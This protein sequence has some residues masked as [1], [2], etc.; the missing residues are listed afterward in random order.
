MKKMV[1]ICLN[2][3]DK[4]G[5][6]RS[7]GGIQTYLYQLAKLGQTLNLMPVI[8]QCADIPFSK[9]IDGIEVVGVKVSYSKFLF[10]VKRQLYKSALSII[11]NNN[12]V[13][14]FGTE[15]LCV[16]SDSKK[17]ICIQ[18]GIDWDLPAHYLSR[19]S[20]KWMIYAWLSKKIKAHASKSNIKKVNTVVC[21]DYN[22]LNWYRACVVDF[23]ISKF[24]VIPNF[25]DVS[26]K[27][28]SSKNTSIKNN[29]DNI[30][31]LFARRFYEYRGTRLMIKV[32]KRILDEFANVQITFAGEG[33][34]YKLIHAEFKSNRRVFLK[35]YD[36]LNSV[37]FHS[38]YNIAV[39]PSMGSE[40]TSLSV[41]EAMAAGCAVVASNVGGITN[42]I[43]NNYNGILISPT[44][45]DVYKAIRSL[46]TDSHLRNKLSNNA[47]EVV[48]NSFSIRRWQEQWTQIIKALYEIEVAS[49]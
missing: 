20:K 18:H 2:F 36:P 45:E 46:I 22:Y 1:I 27:T 26:K 40:G 7:I 49:Q 35:S 19:L 17:A 6:S 8:V 3:L 21:V 13:L 28:L 37:S 48:M 4:E 42:M 32:T 39:V 44:E 12:D 29:N 34:D 16:T 30:N 25:V 23:D 15:H 41:A 5:G 38:E 47:Q 33:P 9:N 24:V 31:I 14:I 10:M 11:D 43:I